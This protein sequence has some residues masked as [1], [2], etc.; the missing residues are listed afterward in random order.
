VRAELQC[1]TESVRET[2]T[3]VER[4]ERGV[5]FWREDQRMI[6]VFASDGMWRK[7]ADIWVEGMP[8][9]SCPDVPPAGLIKPKRGFG[10][11]WCNTAG[12]KAL[13][14]WALDEEHGYTT[15]Y[16]AFQ[17]GEMLRAEDNSVYVLFRS[18]LWRRYP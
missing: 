5:M 8:D 16:Q 11:A 7:I 6:Y 2:W 12:L 1:P 17:G 13:V 4:F 9:Y 14:G 18:G 15:Q 10:Y 3:A